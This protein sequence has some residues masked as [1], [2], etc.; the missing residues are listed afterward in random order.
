M[1]CYADCDGQL[2]IGTGATTK[3][4]QSAIY[5]SLTQAYQ[6]I[7]TLIHAHGIPVFGATITPFSAPSN[8]TGQPYS[9]PEREITRYVSLSLGTL[10][11][12]KDEAAAHIL[13]I[14]PTILF[15]TNIQSVEHTLTCY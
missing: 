12:E 10:R 3:E 4:A 11:E 9:N 14:Y 1:E 15:V 13:R 7:V 2:D 5:E 8:F 6:Q